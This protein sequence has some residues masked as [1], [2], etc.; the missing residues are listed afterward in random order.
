MMG[1]N[2]RLTI[3]GIILGILLLSIV[4]ANRAFQ[5]I[6]GSDQDDPIS[7]VN[8]TRVDPFSDV[9]DRQSDR[10]RSQSN[11]RPID[12]E[13][14]RNEDGELIL[15]P[16]ETAGTYIQRQ[17]RIE[18]DPIV[19]A[20]EV[21]IVAFGN[22]AAASNTP[23]AAQSNTIATDQSPPTTNT[24]T[25]TTVGSRPTSPAPTTAP[26]VPALW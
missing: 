16:L 8:D 17:K 25:N 2:T 24:N 26:A 4:G 18:E 13:R 20:T 9:G 21:E 14:E 19:S 3:G 7:S 23:P 6:S 15:R 1:L 5:S 11:S 22:G 10:A 12:S